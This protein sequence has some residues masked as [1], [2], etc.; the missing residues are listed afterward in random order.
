[1][2]FSLM[3]SVFFFSVQSYRNAHER[4]TCVNAND[5]LIHPLCFPFSK[6]K[7]KPTGPFFGCESLQV[8]PGFDI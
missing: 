7:R 8:F 6:N 3:F 4:R 1:M 2:S 5:L